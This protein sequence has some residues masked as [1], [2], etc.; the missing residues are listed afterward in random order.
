MYDKI[1]K[2]NSG[3]IGWKLI[4]SSGIFVSKYEQHRRDGGRLAS[5]NLA[6]P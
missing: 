5:D 1:T 6:R 4:M 3:D 2:T